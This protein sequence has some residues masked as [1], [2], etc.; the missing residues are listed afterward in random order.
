MTDAQ[1]KAL[2]VGGGIAAA[3]IVAAVAKYSLVRKGA[4][5]PWSVDAVLNVIRNRRHFEAAR[6][7][8]NGRFTSIYRSP[9]YNATVPG[10]VKTSD[11]QHGA[12]VDMVPRGMTNKAA[13]E[14]LWAKVKAGELGDVAQLIEEYKT[15]GSKWL[16]IGW[17]HPKRKGR[18]ARYFVL[19]DGKR[20]PA[21]WQAP[22]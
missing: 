2:F 9:E 12:A 15:G 3:A 5:N 17:N 7:L 20:P 14:K 22:A 13:A 6:E 11:H 18:K 16:H 21:G 10:A 8:V 1:I 4:S 19:L